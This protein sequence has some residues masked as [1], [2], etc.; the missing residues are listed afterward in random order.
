M[1]LITSEGAVLVRAQP[2]S[3]KSMI[4]H[5]VQVQ[6]RTEG[7]EV[8]GAIEV[9]QRTGSLCDG[10]SWDTYPPNNLPKQPSHC[11]T[12]GAILSSGS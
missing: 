6:M 11:T 3:H 9:R 2:G 12:T 8:E 1:A 5:P 10:V 4:K 7:S